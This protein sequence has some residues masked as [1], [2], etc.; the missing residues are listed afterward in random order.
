MIDQVKVLDE[1]ERLIFELR[2][3]NSI[4]SK[5]YLKQGE[6]VKYAGIGSAN[7]LNKWERKGLKKIQIDGVILYDKKDVDNFVLQYKK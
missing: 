5:R 3:E 1:L 6:A 4:C 2:K 7:T